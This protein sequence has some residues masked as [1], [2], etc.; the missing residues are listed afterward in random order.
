[1]DISLLL[2]KNFKIRIYTT[3]TLPIVLYMYLR[4]MVSYIEGIMQTKGILKQD[5]ESN[6]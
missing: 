4:N 2:S 1:M 5:P 6:M 3:I